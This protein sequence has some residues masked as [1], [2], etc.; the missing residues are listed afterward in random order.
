[1]YHVN[2]Q[3]IASL[4]VVLAASLFA[5]AVNACQPDAPHRKAMQENAEAWGQEDQAIH[6]RGIQSPPKQR[7]G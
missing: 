4:F 5:V 1:M 3:D 2:K 7:A 6:A